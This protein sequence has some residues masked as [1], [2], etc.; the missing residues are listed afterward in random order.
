MWAILLFLFALFVFSLYVTRIQGQ[1]K[2]NEQKS[3]RRP[4]Y[5]C[6]CQCHT[7][8]FSEQASSPTSFLAMTHRKVLVLSAYATWRSLWVW[9]ALLSSLTLPNMFTS[10]SR[11][12]LYSTYPGRFLGNDNSHI[13]FTFFYLQY[14]WFLSI[15]VSVSPRK[16]VWYIFNCLCISSTK[17][18]LSVFLNGVFK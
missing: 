2:L 17:V 6:I 5:C 11:F 14:L 8:L 13:G 10:L 16:Q 15:H 18:L 3:F 7:H 9:Q 4:T 1:Q 12:A